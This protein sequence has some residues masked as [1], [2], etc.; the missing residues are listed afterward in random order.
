MTFEQIKLEIA[1]RLG[2][3]DITRTRAVVGRAFEQAVTELAISDETAHQDIPDIIVN[4][5]GD[6]FGEGAHL[7]DFLNLTAKIEFPS[8]MV[9][10]LDVYQNPLYAFS[11]NST[12]LENLILKEISW[13][14]A[15]RARQEQAFKPAGNEVFWYKTTTQVWFLMSN[16]WAGLNGYENVWVVLS[17]IKNPDM[18]DWTEDVNLVNDLGYSRNFIYKCITRAIQTLSNNQNN[19]SGK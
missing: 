7:L 9:K 19:P 2:D 1:K 4:E 14:E 6:G 3:D 18:T 10:F 15:K 11:W 13:E 17:Y 12:T 16:D 5:R 8:N